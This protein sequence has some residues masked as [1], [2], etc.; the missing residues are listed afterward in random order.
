MAKH[1]RRMGHEVTILTTRAFGTL[2]DDDAEGVVRSYDLQLLQARLHGRREAVPILEADTYSNR[3]HP[4]SYVIVPEAL[5]LA[6]TPFALA[7][8]VSLSRRRRYDCVITARPRSR[9]I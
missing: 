7:R 2:A 9:L 1:L 4:L 8:A 6:W 3:P 5:A